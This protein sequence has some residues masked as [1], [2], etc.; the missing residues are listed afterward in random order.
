MTD[1]Q[2]FLAPSG[3]PGYTGLYRVKA[4]GWLYA[5]QPDG[6]WVPIRRYEDFKSKEGEA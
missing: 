1:T 3:T 6:V 2:R 5:I 4:D